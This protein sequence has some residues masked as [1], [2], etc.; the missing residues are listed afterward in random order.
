ML[1]RMSPRS[2]GVEFSMTIGGMFACSATATL[3]GP[4]ILRLFYASMAWFWESWEEYCRWCQPVAIRRGAFVLSR[5]GTAYQCAR[6][7]VRCGDVLRDSQKRLEALGLNRTPLSGRLTD[8]AHRARDPA[9][10]AI[11]AGETMLLFHKRLAKSTAADAFLQAHDFLEHWDR[12]A[13]GPRIVHELRELTTAI[14]HLLDGNERIENDDERFLLEDLE[15]PKQL[16]GDFRLAKNLFSAGFDEAGLFIAARGLEEVVRQIVRQRKIILHIGKK[17]EP[18]C[19]ADL[20]DL[21]EVMARLRWKASGEPVLGK[22]DK[23]LLQ[24]IRTTRNVGAH[25]SGKDADGSSCRHTAEV[26]A[27]AS[28]KLWSSVASKRARFLITDVEKNWG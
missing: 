3:P 10:S 6:K 20:Y 5:S 18:A 22:T 14:D 25:R 17:F 11:H 9:V 26:I 23:A 15:L 27:R 24:Y 28:S 13:A 19:E 2:L 8:L 21:I 12:Y 7:L 16:E 4:A 1:A